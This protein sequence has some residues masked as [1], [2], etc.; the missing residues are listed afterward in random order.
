[1]TEDNPTPPPVP[2]PPTSA[3]AQAIGN[4][5]LIAIALL[6]A[7]SLGTAYELYQN[8]VTSDALLIALTGS[9]SLMLVVLL[10]CL[11]GIVVAKMA[12]NHINLALLVAEDD[13]GASLSRFQMLLFTFVI[14]A[15]YL[16]Y[17]LYTL[18]LASA[19]TLVL[20]EIPNGVLGLIGISGGSY[21]ASKGIQKSAET[22]Q[23]SKA[24]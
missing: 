20:P 12:S 5:A 10:S 2:T 7:V 1:M 14:A 6:A 22:L 3:P 16:V 23:N 9:A 18:K 21:V 13:G 8:Q 19:G 15:L 4:R 24:P 11:G 17:T